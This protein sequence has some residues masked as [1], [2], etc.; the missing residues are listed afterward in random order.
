MTLPIASNSF[1]NLEIESIVKEVKQVKLEE[2]DESLIGL[3]H[4]VEKTDEYIFVLDANGPRVLQFDLNG[5]YIKEIGRNGNGSNEYANLTTFT[6]DNNLKHIYLATLG[7]VVRYDFDNNFI[8]SYSGI[9]LP[10]Y[11]HFQNGLLEVYFTKDESAEDGK[12]FVKR[13]LL[14]KIHDNAV[15]EDSVVT[16]IVKIKKQVYTVFQRAKYL[17]ADLDQKFFYQPVLIPEE[18]IRDTLYEVKNNQLI[19]AL[20]LSFGGSTRG[21]DGMKS[22]YIKSI[23]RSE[24]FL[25]AEYLNSGNR[26]FV[27]DFNKSKGYNLKEGINGGKYTNNETLE[28]FPLNNESNEFYFN[29]KIVSDEDSYEP[30]PTLFFVQFK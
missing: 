26:L 2:T 3:I 29:S 13:S 24:N 30:N 17:S 25:F 5:K 1:Q 20:K 23:I 11:A 6:I 14:Y 12:G 19:P 16:K 15:I 7:K 21:V 18:I 9:A 22:I 4:K 10:E 8:D 28:L 27:Y